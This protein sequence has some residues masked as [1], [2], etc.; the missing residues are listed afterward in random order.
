ML[1]RRAFPRGPQ[2]PVKGDELVST[3]R[4]DEYRCAAAV[5]GGHNTLDVTRPGAIPT[6]WMVKH[7][8]VPM[9]PDK[10]ALKPGHT[11]MR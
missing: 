3:G 2:Y 1:R 6:T 5:V 4:P 10:T 8:I 9:G 11:V 7:F